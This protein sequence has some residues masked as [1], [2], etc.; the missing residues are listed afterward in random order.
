MKL[1]EENSE[2]YG[3]DIHTSIIKENLLG[4]KTMIDIARDSGFSITYVYGI[5]KKILNNN[6]RYKAGK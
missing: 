2:H 5:R 4:N 1:I 3:T 6:L